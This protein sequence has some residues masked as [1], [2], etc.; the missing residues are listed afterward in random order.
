LSQLIESQTKHDQK[1][2][3]Q[4]DKYQQIT[5]HSLCAPSVRPVNSTFPRQ[6]PIILLAMIS[7]D[8]A[9]AVLKAG[10]QR[11]KSN[12]RDLDAMASNARRGKAVHAQEPFAIILGCS[13]SRVPAEIVFDQGLGDLFVIRVAGNIV[14]PSLLGSVEFSAVKH[15]A[16][17]VVVL[18][19]THCGAIEATIS[20][21]KQ[22]T[23][24]R[25][26]NL[27]SIVSRIQ[28]S[29]QTLLEAGMEQ[30][31]HKLISLATRANVRASVSQ[32]RHGSQILENL[33]ASDGLRI[34]GAEYVLET[35][36]VEF[37]NDDDAGSFDMAREH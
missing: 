33:I 8:E 11:F 30:D 21:L 15:G 13:D 18:G 37:F 19:H 5:T 28:P 36:E 27:Q 9:L 7:A 22:P 29:V 20:E 14:A 6:F 2:Q 12:V 23:S 25:S 24:N 3:G 31:D 16:R 4:L 1:Y 26:P 17:L 10:N 35:G 34:V 32:L